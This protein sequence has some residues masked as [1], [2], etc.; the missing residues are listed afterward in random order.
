MKRLPLFLAL[1]IALVCPLFIAAKP[2]ETKKIVFIAGN[3]SHASGEHEFNAG[4]H[5]LAKALNEQSGLNV[6]ATVVRSDWPKKHKDVV[7][8]ADTIVIYADAVSGHAGQWEFLDEL[9][10]KGVGMVFMHYAVHPN[11]DIGKKYYQPWIGGAMETDWSVNPHWVADLK[12]MEGHEISN[13]VPESI[14]CLDEWYYNMR[15]VPERDQVLDLFTA[16]PTRDNMYK[17]INLWNEYGVDGLDKPQTLM[18]GYERP[19]GGRGV[20][21]T[22]GHYHHTWALDGVR[23]AVLN[24]IVWTAGIAVPADGVKSTTPT[25]DEFNA[26]LDDY[27]EKTKRLKLPN[28]EDW[29]KLPPAKVNEKREAGFKKIPETGGESGWIDLF[30]GKDLTGFHRR[31]GTATYE[32]KDGTILGTTVKGSPNSFL[33][34]DKEYGDFELTFEVK[35]HDRLNSGV[36]I[37]S[38]TLNDDPDERVNGPQVEIEASG[39]K[40]AEAGYLYGEASGGWMTPKDKR[41]P[42][43]HFKDGEWNSYRI[44][45]EGPRIQVWVN[46]VQVSDLVDEKKFETHPKGFIGLQVH[47]VGNAGPFDV[48][49]RNLKIREIK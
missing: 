20:G 17:Y 27:G 2:A 49:W 46:G 7:A 30:N 35:C 8:A 28:P 5:L 44:L 36:Q 24:A 3:R 38:Q 9:A 33:C 32:V 39:K 42:H 13:G 18:W 45:A 4:C 47:G 10:K 19:N 48:A 41:Q 15:F 12:I 23:T 14:T 1:F 40:G 16:V 43:K 29:K 37:R 34:T 25:E 31:N 11:P 26:N 6:E 21:F 22:G